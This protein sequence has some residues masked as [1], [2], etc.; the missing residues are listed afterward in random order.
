[1]EED[2]TSLMESTG[3]GLLPGLALATV[4]VLSIMA[5][6]LMESIWAVALILI[7]VLACTGLVAFV[8]VAVTAEGD[9]AGRLRR[10]VPG[11]SERG[12]TER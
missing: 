8:V 2:R 6:L 3:M 11:L 5:A 4:L 9:E 12:P 1:M 7:V 10:L